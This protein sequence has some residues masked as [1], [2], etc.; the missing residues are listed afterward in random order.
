MD[1]NM[2]IMDGYAA[3]EEIRKHLGRRDTL[4]IGASAYPKREIEARGG[5]AGMDDFIG[6]P[7][8]PADVASCLQKLKSMANRI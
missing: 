2:P 1:I 3:T 5:E 4:I 7:L 6:K 8:N